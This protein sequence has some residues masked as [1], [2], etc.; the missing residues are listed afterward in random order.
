MA[1]IIDQIETEDKRPYKKRRHY[2]IRDKLPIEC[3]LIE[4]QKVYQGFNPTSSSD[5]T[6]VS[7]HNYLKSQG[8]DGYSTRN[9]IRN[10]LS[11]QSILSK[12]NVYPITKVFFIHLFGSFKKNG[13]SESILVSYNEEL[14]L[15][16]WNFVT[17]NYI[18]NGSSRES[19]IETSFKKWEENKKVCKKQDQKK[20]IEKPVSGNGNSTP[21]PNNG[22][23][24][25]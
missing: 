1:T 8:Y 5:K 24:K 20:V 7:F 2:E 12:H 21:S 19:I 11:V 10:Y 23:R 3:S 16:Y 25:K 14:L 22:S 17:V 18:H 9:T 4:Y 13:I 6:K 15:D